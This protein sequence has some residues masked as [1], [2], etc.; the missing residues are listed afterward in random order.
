MK[1]IVTRPNVELQTFIDYKKDLLRLN[2]DKWLLDTR[3]QE[4]NEHDFS[5]INFET[6]LDLDSTNTISIISPKNKSVTSSE[7]I[8]HTANVLSNRSTQLSSG[9]FVD[10]GYSDLSGNYKNKNIIVIDLYG[11][12]VGR[13]INN[14]ISSNGSMVQLINDINSR[15]I[16]DKKGAPNSTAL[17]MP[18]SSNRFELIG[19]NNYNILVGDTLYTSYKSDIY[20]KDI[21]VCMVVRVT[22]ASNN[23]GFKKIIVELLADFK[24]LEYVFVVESNFENN[25]VDY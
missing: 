24:N 15:V 20:I 18:F 21:P 25:R 2:L 10:I 13:V 11:N 22:D 3:M 6:L 12:L 16:V 5:F 14:S 1:S 19:S 7:N 9:L 17:L 23:S 8:F 4:L